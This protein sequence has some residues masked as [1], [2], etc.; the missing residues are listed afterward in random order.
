MCPYCVGAQRT[1]RMATDSGAPRSAARTLLA[2][3][4]SIADRGRRILD[5]GAMRGDLVATCGRLVSGHGE[6]TSL[7]LAM[8]IVA[9]LDGLDSDAA[10]EFLG[11]LRDRFSPDPRAMESAISAWLDKR[12][13]TALIRLAGA[14]EPPR[15]E[16][17]RRLNM[18]PGG[19][20]AIVRLR[21]QLLEA[22]HLHPDLSVVDA[23]LRHLLAS[24]FNRGFLRLERI[25]WESP[26][27]VLER[28]IRYEAV[29]E[30]ESWEDLHLRLA[31]DRRC[32]AYFHPAL[33]QEPLIFVEVALCDGLAVEL[34]PLL[35]RGR[36]VGDARRTNT[37]IFYSI[38]NCQPGLRGISFGSFL[39]KQVAAE[40]ATEL[41]RVT[42]FATL[43]PLP[44]LASAFHDSNAGWFTEPRL[45]SILGPL[46]PEVCRAANAVELRPA[47]DSLA[48]NPQRTELAS[49]ALHRVALAYLLEARQGGRVA[50]PVLHFHSSNGARLERINPN[51]DLTP[52]GIAGSFGVMANYVYDL[53]RLE[54]N[55]ERYVA[56]GRVAVAP[57][58]A[59][60]AK[61]IS[62]AWRAANRETL[63]KRSGRGKQ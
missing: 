53:E 9:V 22:L 3:V 33:P 57:K 60:E 15:Q 28:L 17:F 24:W 4:A 47:L 20:A 51:A 36:R 42:A 7:A 26:A 23:D 34:R 63:G 32:F 31:A 56:S 21:G 37:A 46:A 12:D 62:E 25:T 41:P 58:L 50:D 38:S 29:H 61:H 40:I 18:V 30:I 14:V 39:L 6:A 10:I 5:R 43:S 27:S 45:K 44:G 16:L 54:E 1:R 48:R 49:K 2:Q 19:T 35:D 59:R 52:H 55:H 11:A 13:A 8:K